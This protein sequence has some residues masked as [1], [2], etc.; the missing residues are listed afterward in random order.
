VARRE[1]DARVVLAAGL[2]VWG[3]SDRID[4]HCERVCAL[5]LLR[6]ALGLGESVMYPA[7]FKLLAR[8][9]LDEQRGRANGLPGG[10]QSWAL[11]LVL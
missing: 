6:L 5:L 10:G 9:A 3:W 2:A 8:D 11:P 7:S 1:A 4:R